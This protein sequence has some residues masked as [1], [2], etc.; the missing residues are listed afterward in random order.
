[1]TEAVR[2]RRCRWFVPAALLAALLAYCAVNCVR[3]SRQA[4]IDE[5][6]PA[7]VII[8][9]GAAEYAGHPSPIYRA[10]LDHALSLYRRGLAPIIITTG[11]SGGDPHFTEGEV[12]RNYL[13]AQDVPDRNLIAET[14]GDNTAESAERVAVILRANGMKSCIAVTDPYHL[15][16][17]KRLLESEGFAVYA[18]GRPTPEAAWLTRTGRVLR[19][20]ASYTMWRLYLTRW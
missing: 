5:A 9:F 2:K 12:G 15:F 6:R 16:R 17:A 4:G 8:V 1:M 3:V 19:E 18:S 10:R 20:S 13:A 11:G 14:Q 7:D